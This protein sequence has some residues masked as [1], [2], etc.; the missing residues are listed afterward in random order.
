[1]YQ[2]YV[3]PYESGWELLQQASLKRE[4]P[5]TVELYSHPDSEKRMK[6]QGV[7]IRC[8][9]C[10][11]DVQENENK[12]VCVLCKD[13]F[14]DQCLK[15]AVSKSSEEWICQR[16]QQYTTPSWGDLPICVGC[17]LPIQ[18]NEVETKCWRCCRCSGLFHHN[19]VKTTVDDPQ[20][21][22]CRDCCD[23]PDNLDS[24]T[25]SILIDPSSRFLT[26][27]YSS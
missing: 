10:N 26:C 24:L 4:L 3:E 12:R 8:S 7:G 18:E 1:M 19:C 5:T 15:G 11:V 27:Y 22:I 6:E 25:S 14:C 16:C 9:L 20:S 13:T 2:R 23:L 21:W 17:G